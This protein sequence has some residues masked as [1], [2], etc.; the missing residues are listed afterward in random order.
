LAHELN[1]LE[2]FNQ[3][4]DRFR[5]IGPSSVQSRS[6]SPTFVATLRLLRCCLFYFRL[7]YNE[8]FVTI[9]ILDRLGVTLLASLNVRPCQHVEA[10]LTSSSQCP[11]ALDGPAHAREDLRAREPPGEGP[12]GS[13][14][15]QNR[16]YFREPGL[17]ESEAST[18]AVASHTG[19]AVSGTDSALRLRAPSRLACA[20]WQTVV[21]HSR[22][23]TR[24]P[25]PTR[26][27]PVGGAE[28]AKAHQGCSL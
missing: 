14:F 2:R 15:D 28:P 18:L 19:R 1:R 22:A 25:P 12:G 6:R 11:R 4:A 16:A 10:S 7:I 21:V 9:E 27:R 13:E 24:Y 17:L 20:A 5:T 23:A 26:T 3:I 8:W